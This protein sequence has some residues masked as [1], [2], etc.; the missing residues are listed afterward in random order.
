M[1]LDELREIHSADVRLPTTDGRELRVRCVV[2]PEPAQALLLDR[3]G[4]KLPRRLRLASAI[5]TSQT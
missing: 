5:P 3:L 4:L 1:I 2:K